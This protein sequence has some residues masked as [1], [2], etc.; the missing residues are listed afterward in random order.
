MSASSVAAAHASHPDGLPLPR[1]YWAIAA[2]ALGIAM[3]VLDSTIVNVALPT[4]AR[5]F[6]ATAAASIWVIN[7]YQLAILL[8]LLPFA[9]LGEIIGYRRV[10]Q[11]GLAIFTIASLGCAFAP[12]LLALSLARVVQGIGAAGIMSVNGALVRHIYPHARLGQG[13][14]LN[15]MVV[16]GSLALGPTVASAI[17]SVGPWPWLFGVN[18]PI[19]VAAMAVGWTNLPRNLLSERR[20]DWLS[21]LFNALAFGLVIT[22]VDVL[23][24]TRAKLAGA[25]E[26]VAGLAVGAVLV[27]RELVLPRPLVPFDLLRKPLFALSVATSIGSFAAQTLAFVSLP[28]LFETVMRHDQVMTGF[29]LTPWPA[30]VGVMAPIAG[31]LADRFSTAILCAIGLVLFGLGLVALAVMPLGAAPLDIGWRMALCG[32]G[33]GFFQSPNN[34]MMLGSAPRDRA[35]AAGGMLGTARL[36]GQTFGAGLTAIFLHF[37][38]DRGEVAALW[39]AAGFAAVAAMVSLTRTAVRAEAPT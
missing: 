5:D 7:A 13:I 16:S 30:A 11:A 1:R 24:R 14:G 26:L 6:R 35:G 15:A 22:S 12:N 9:S 23:T 29:L 18:V 2:I 8:V 34:R 39:A 4:I 19:G 28:F 10:S 3:S 37:L 25:L 36:T 17:L 20:F 32:V 31:W 38:G 27:R 33:F 21:A